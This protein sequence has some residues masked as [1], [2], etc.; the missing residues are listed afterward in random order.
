MPPTLERGGVAGQFSPRV[1]AL[2]IVAASVFAI[3]LLDQ[4]IALFLHHLPN[5]LTRDLARN[6]P[7]LGNSG[8]LFVL[9]L[10]A[11]LGYRLLFGNHERCRMA[12]LVIC[13]GGLSWL[14]ANVLK[15]IFGRMRPAAFIDEGAYG[16]D[17]FTSAA[18]FDSFPS[19]HAAVAAGLASGLAILWPRNRAAIMNVAAAM[20][21]TKVITGDHF[22]SDAMI[23]FAVGLCSGWIVWLLLRRLEFV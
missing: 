20:T 22:L 8:P 1:R 2:D 23:G 3:L 5:N 16:F 4:P 15:G 10:V 9:G 11:L 14:C 7:D 13:A 17:F 19:G 6:V 18:N 12:L 21:A